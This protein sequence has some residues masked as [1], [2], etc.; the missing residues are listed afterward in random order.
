V[1]WALEHPVSGMLGRQI[2]V[3]SLKLRWGDPSHIVAE[4]VA[5]ANASWGS[6]PE[7]FMAKRI[8]VDL[9]MRSLLWGPARIPR[10]A[11]DGARLLL[12]TSK[13]GEKNW[14]FGL[15]AAA[16]KKRHQFPDLREFAVKDGALSFHN[17]EPTPGRISPSPIS[18]SRKRHRRSRSTLPR[19]GHSRE[20]P[21][22]L[23]D[24]WAVSAPC[25]IPASLIR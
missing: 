22:G 18:R 16:P 19:T 10:I 11:L 2:R 15:S 17:G 1:A 9:F 4:N 6:A 3:G 8:E 23:R 24:A 21:C 7:M 12:E 13:N 14:D 5:V 20:R 25:A